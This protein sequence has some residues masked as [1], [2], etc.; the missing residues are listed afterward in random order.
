[1]YPTNEREALEALKGDDPELAATAE[2]LLWSA[3]CR[4]GDPEA[5]RIFRLG[6]EAMQQG[7]LAD[8]EEFFDRV[9]AL[10]PD[11]TGGYAGSD[12]GHGGAGTASDKG[13]VTWHYSGDSVVIEGVVMK[14][15]A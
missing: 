6:V 2:A 12:C 15:A 7:K 11:F 10:K 13:D 9:I 3:W 8:A 5:D 1:M 14:P 4:S